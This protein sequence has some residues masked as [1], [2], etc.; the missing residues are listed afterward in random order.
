MRAL[1]AQLEGL[2]AVLDADERVVAASEAFAVHLGMPRADVEARQLSELPEIAARGQRT[3]LDIDGATLLTLDAPVLGASL[4]QVLDRIGD[5]FLTFD[6]EWRYT[7]VNRAAE[8]YI[9]RPRRS[10]LGKS[11]WELYPEVIGSELERAYR[12]AAAGH[13]PVELEL[14]TPVKSR[15]IAQRLYPTEAGLTV[16]FRDV[17]EL[18]LAG[19][20]L[21]LSEARWRALFENSLDG[22]ALTRPDGRIIAM[23]P[24]GC[25]MLRRSEQEICAMGR[26]G[27]VDSSDPR[28][29]A[30]V[31]ERRRS[32][33]AAGELT[34]LRGDGS[35][36][37]AEFTSAVFHDAA[38]EKLTS[39][40]FRDLTER[41]RAE[42]SRRIKANAGVVLQASLDIAQTLENLAKLLVPELADVCL[43]DV[44]EHGEIR[45]VVAQHRDPAFAEATRLL[46]RPAPEPER[47]RPIS[48]SGLLETRRS[49]LVHTVT[50]EWLEKNARNEVHLEALRSIA[51]TSMMLV[52]LVARGVAIGVLTLMSVNPVHHYDDLD[53]ELARSIGEQA[54][55]AIDNARLYGA[56]L[57]ARRQRDEVLAVVSHDLRNPLNAIVLYAQILS[58]RMASRE[59]DAIRVAAARADHMVQDLLTIATIEA[60]P[61]PL[62]RRS[63]AVSSIVEEV[64]ALC[65]ALAEERGLLLEASVEPELP[66]AVVDRHR[67]VQ[68]LSNLVGN[69]LK[70]TPRGGRVA[71]SAARAGGA[72]KLEVADSGPGIPAEEVPHLFER[73]WQ[74]Q[75]PGGGGVGLGLA[76]TK[77]IVEA[78]GGAVAVESVIRHGSKFMLS[79]PLSPPA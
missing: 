6:R 71:L 74:G 56:A 77:G 47:R 12:A 63:E 42:E 59:L 48:I 11:I 58:K 16:S 50:D 24:A 32:G 79:L 61:L 7:F 10:L 28:L 46:E 53:L 20:A 13:E 55:F 75:A 9:G 65:R 14:R 36:F 26:A 22:V 68:A 5:G 18:K 35:S 38:G 27:V 70:F 39:L 2:V 1:V 3:P 44:I 19:D 72:L 33:R 73:F 62:D 8:A 66:D 51:P 54:A 64:V 15:W 45:R 23:N 31:E 57:E 52:P 60:G 78:H 29:P 43:V 69:A 37:P 21:R 49:E 76:I 4:E 17:T 40:S 25:R 41:K 67:I 30:L 34:M